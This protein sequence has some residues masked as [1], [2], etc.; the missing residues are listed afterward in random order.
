MRF[1]WGGM[2]WGDVS[3]S[4]VHFDPESGR[5]SHRVVC[6]GVASFGVELRTVEPIDLWI[7]MPK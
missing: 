6:L 4:V 3:R 1:T 2:S 7:R 5:R